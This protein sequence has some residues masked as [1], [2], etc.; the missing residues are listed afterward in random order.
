MTDDHQ[1]ERQVATPLVNNGV[2][3]PNVHS[4]T[5]IYYYE[6]EA[7]YLCQ[8]CVAVGQK[9]NLAAP[10]R[11]EANE[12]SQHL[13]VVTTCPYSRRGPAIHVI[14]ETNKIVFGVLN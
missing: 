6:P 4:K 2:S 7:N 5:H 13:V 3:I 9:I 12:S 14:R 8:L 1:S 11:F 10:L